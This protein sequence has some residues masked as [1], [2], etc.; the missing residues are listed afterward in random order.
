ML[1]RATI[2]S[3]ACI[4]RMMHAHDHFRMML[5]SL[6]TGDPIAGEWVYL[7]GLGR[8]PGSSRWSEHFARRKNRCIHARTHA[9]VVCGKQAASTRS[10]A[11]QAQTTNATESLGPAQFVGSLEPVVVATFHP[12]LLAKTKANGTEA[13]DMVCAV[14]GGDRSLTLWSSSGNT[15]IFVLNN[16]FDKQ[17]LALDP[18]P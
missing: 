5:A 14:G 13:I 15:P 16:L 11:K 3:C 18:K 2:E 7:C 1:G 4:F 6:S 9:L 8:Q 12:K 17:V 10:R